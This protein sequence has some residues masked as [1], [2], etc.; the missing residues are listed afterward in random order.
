MKNI[1]WDL[2]VRSY[3]QT[4]IQQVTLAFVIN[5]HTF[6]F[7]ARRHV[8]D[9]L[10]GCYELP[11]GIL[12]KTETVEEGSTRI[13]KN[14]FNVD[15][16]CIERFLSTFTYTS[17]VGKQCRCFIFAVTIK[18][19]FTLKLDRNDHGVWMNIQDLQK[20]PIITH[21]SQALLLFWIGESYHPWLAHTLIEQAKRENVWRY[22]V[23][24]LLHQA[25]EFLLLKRARRMRTMPLMYELP[26]KEI[27][28]AEEIDS[29][30]IQATYEQTGSYPERI[31]KFLGAYDYISSSSRTPVREFIYAVKPQE[32]P[33][34]LSEHAYYV[35]VK[36]CSN[37]SISVTPCVEYAYEQYKKAFFVNPPE[38]IEVPPPIYFQRPLNSEEQSI[39]QFL[40]S[41]HELE[42]YGRISNPQHLQ[43]FLLRKN[44]LPQNIR[45]MLGL[46]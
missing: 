44:S 6:S 36:D 26:G 23:R 39:Q 29:V 27:K 21:F 32:K 34:I 43:K 2:L 7:I 13:L 17:A 19:P 24:I 46:N 10:P 20:W 38:K 25:E 12:L 4:I 33:I 37:A 41:L 8:E 30:I 31:T 15:L 22:K 11:Q 18:D 9:F 45:D 42:K 3:T 28:Q 35:W 16:T 14:H 1:D 5:H 40:E